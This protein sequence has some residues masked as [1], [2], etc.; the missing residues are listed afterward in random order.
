M[1]QL[2]ENIQRINVFLRDKEKKSFPTVIKEI[3]VLSLSKG[4]FP[5]YYFGRFLYRKN[6]T[7][8]K[9][10]L[11]LKEYYA[12]LNSKVYNTKEY[13]Y[14]LENKLCFALFC[15]ENNLP[16]PKTICYNMKSMFLGFEK[17][18]EI[19]TRESFIEYIHSIFEKINCDRIFVKTVSGSGGKGVYLLTR[20]NLDSITNAQVEK[21][22]KSVCIYQEG[23]I[24]HENLNLLYANSIN[25]IRIDTYI[26]NRNQINILSSGIRIGTGNNYVDNISSGGVFVPADPST[27]KLGKYSFQSMIHGGKK[28]THHPDTK[29]EFL[30]FQIPFFEEAKDLCLQLTKHLPS[31]LIGWDIAITPKGPIV[32]EGNTRPGFLLGEIYHKGYRNHPIGKEMLTNVRP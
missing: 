23:V 28:Y 3:T 30:D 32:I 10:Y 18:N 16:T 8:Y 1:G 15:K 14:I 9:D 26:D 2:R 27:G 5:L 19:Q 22:M 4:H 17:K 25:T 11:S 7:N 20:E 12:I 6:I 29:V 21:I 13:T 31:R 24:Q